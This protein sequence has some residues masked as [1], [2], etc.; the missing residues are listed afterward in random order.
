MRDIIQGMPSPITIDPE[1]MS[2]TPCFTGTRVPVRSLIDYLEGG[3]T[4]DE[5]LDDFPTVTREVA[6]A[7]LELASE[8]ALAEAVRAAG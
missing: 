7:Y 2:G 1:I 5:F 4:L 6:L 8:K 3:Y